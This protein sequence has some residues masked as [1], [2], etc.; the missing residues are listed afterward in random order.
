[1]SLTTLAAQVKWYLRNRKFFTSHHKSSRLGTFIQIIPIFE[2]QLWRNSRRKTYRAR[3]SAMGR[4]CWQSNDPKIPLI[5]DR[6]PYQKARPR[7]VLTLLYSY[8]NST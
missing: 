8:K 5:I 7:T 2:C 6:R 4:K 1:M 3:K